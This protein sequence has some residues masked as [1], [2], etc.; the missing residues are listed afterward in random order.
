M[1]DIN[2]K[3]GKIY[4]IE[5]LEGKQKIGGGTT[6]MVRVESNRW[7]NYPCKGTTALILDL[8]SLSG[9]YKALFN[10]GTIGEF[11]IASDRFHEVLK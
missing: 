10:D 7:I 4:E 6:F 2:V 11:Y 9:F 8:P 1:N 5:S 3:I